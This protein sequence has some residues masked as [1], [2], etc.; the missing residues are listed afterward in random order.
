MELFGMKFFSQRREATVP[1]DSSSGNKPEAASAKVRTNA[2]HINGQMAAFTVAEFARAIQLRAQTFARAQ[3]EYQIC[4]SADV[5]KKGTWGKR[6]GLNYML[7][8]KPNSYQNAQQMWEMASRIS[9]LSHNGIC[10]IYAPGMSNDN[11]VGL[12]PCQGQW[13]DFDN[14]YTISN[15]KL[16]ICGETVPASECIVLSNGYGMSMLTMLRRD[17]ETSA[18]ATEFNKDTLAKGGTFKAIVKQEQTGSL[19]SGMDGFDDDEV[20]KNFEDINRQFREGNDFIYDPS[21]ANITQ[22]SQSFQD[23]QLPQT[24]DQCIGSVCRVTG[25]PLPLMFLSTNAV[26]KSVDDAFHTFIGL[27]LEPR[28]R[29]II[30]ELNSK[31]LSA[32]DYGR[33]RYW[34]NTTALCLDS[35]KSKA[36]TMS[37]LVNA[38]ILTPNEA[39]HRMNLE[40]KE[41][42]DTLK[43]PKANTN[44]LSNGIGEKGG[45]E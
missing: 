9:D 10:V 38:G 44:T 37:V 40:A 33:I 5:W 25:V 2:V 31:A 1:G 14:T 41:G 16:H 24:K 42:G 35:D 8:V 34:V 22:I 11:I 43:D 27:T 17:L 15:E 20:E 23:L 7:H 39:R 28:W 45:E 6:Q 29:E 36:D 4:T 13:N 26:Y 19:L 32:Y 21:A 3:F 12:Y 30:L 18:T